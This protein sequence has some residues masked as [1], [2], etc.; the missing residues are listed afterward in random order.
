MSALP[1]ELVLHPLLA[2]VQLEACLTGLAWAGHVLPREAWGLVQAGAA[3][4]V[5]VRSPE[6]RHFVGRV[7]GSLHVPWASGTALT[8]NPRFARELQA[9]LSPR[10]PLLMLCRSGERAQAAAEAATRAGFMYAF[11]VLEGFEGNLDPGQR[12]GRL[13]GWRFHGL[14]WT[15]D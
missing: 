1:S 8:R 3:V 11:S 2:Q 14:P 6:E 10:Q 9:R 7:P 13:N 4:L 12:R 5:D 15:Q